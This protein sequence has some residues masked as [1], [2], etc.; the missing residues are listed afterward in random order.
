MIS[1]LLNSERTENEVRENALS[2][3]VNIVM[4]NF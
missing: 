2:N 1:M 4:R 3:K